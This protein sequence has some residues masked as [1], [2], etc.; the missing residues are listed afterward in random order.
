M[1]LI[2]TI[3]ETELN[4]ADEEIELPLWVGEEVTHDPA[5]RKRNLAQRLI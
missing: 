1:A 3:A 2:L 5:Y 4:S